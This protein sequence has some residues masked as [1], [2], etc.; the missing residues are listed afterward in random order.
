[1]QV[2]EGMIGGYKGLS[3]EIVYHIG[4]LF[5][6]GLIVDLLGNNPIDTTRADV[7]GLTAGEAFCS[8]RSQTASSQDVTH[9]TLYVVDEGGASNLNPCLP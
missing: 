2:L 6:N 7:V 3:L 5:C 1:M 8:T 4:F 9:S